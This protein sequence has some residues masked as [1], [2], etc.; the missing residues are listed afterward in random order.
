[1]GADGQAL[2]APAVQRLDGLQAPLL[3]ALR[4]FLPNR[5]EEALGTDE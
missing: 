3:V 1:V 4:E 5:V 2:A